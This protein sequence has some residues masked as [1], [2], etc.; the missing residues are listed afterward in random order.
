[1]RKESL[2][3]INQTHKWKDISHSWIRRLNIVVMSVL[4]KSNIQIRY[5][6][7]SKSQ[8]QFFAEVEKFILKFIWNLKRPQI[9]QN[10]LEKE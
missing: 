6:F 2:Q 4:P 7:L 5:K 8:G 3:K 10:S 1:M 9:S